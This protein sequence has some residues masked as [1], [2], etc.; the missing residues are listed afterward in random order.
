MHKTFQVGKFLLCPIEMAD[1][2]FLFYVHAGFLKEKLTALNFTETAA[3]IYTAESPVCNY[4]GI[5]G[6]NSTSAYIYIY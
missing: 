3:T 2:P 1:A 4:G 6:S 5:A